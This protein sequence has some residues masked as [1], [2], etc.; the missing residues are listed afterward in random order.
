MIAEDNGDGTYTCEINTESSVGSYTAATASIMMPVN[1]P[2]YSAMAPLTS[3]SSFT[4]YTDEGFVYVH[5][6]CRGRD[7]GAPAGARDLKAAVRY[8]RYTDDVLPGN[9]E[10]IFTFGIHDYTFRLS[11]SQ[12]HFQKSQSTTD[13]FPAGFRQ[14]L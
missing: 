2:G 6:G 1:T 4:E 11:K 3:Y 7:S 13:C 14:S 12:Y 8:I 9:A 5:A 10:S